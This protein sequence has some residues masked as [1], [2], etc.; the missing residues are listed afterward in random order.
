MKYNLSKLMKKAWAIYRKAAGS[1]SEA[2]KAA[3]IWIRVQAANTAKVEAAA[4]AA[5]IVEV[6]HYWAG[7]RSVGRM[8]ML[9]QTLYTPISGRLYSGR[10][11]GVSTMKLHRGMES[12]N[13]GQHTTSV[14]IKCI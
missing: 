10:M 8:V 6:I 5:G 4:N 9:W 2:L 3:W 13:I 1:F 7:W 14:M 11:I 12:A